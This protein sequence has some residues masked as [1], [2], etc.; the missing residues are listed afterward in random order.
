M[1]N[2]A[3]VRKNYKRVFFLCEGRS[4]REWHSLRTTQGHR[5]WHRPPIG[6]RAARP[7]VTPKKGDVTFDG[8]SASLR[9]G[10]YY[11][12]HHHHHHHHH[13]RH[14]CLVHQNAV[15]IQSQIRQ[16]IDRQD[17]NGERLVREFTAIVS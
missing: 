5:G 17:V 8:Y 3:Q 6:R 15:N 12:H 16:T 7:S 2:I 10:M 9:P 11:S 1:R 4:P 14:Y 13:H